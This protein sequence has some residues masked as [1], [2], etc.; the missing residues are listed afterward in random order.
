MDQPARL[1]RYEI[2]V[3][4]QPGR[5]GSAHPLAILV[6]R[7]HLKEGV[8]AILS[9]V[10]SLVLGAFKVVMRWKTQ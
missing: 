10:P 7:P 8:S 1:I 4:P 5:L 6:C 9:N 3:D 2:Q